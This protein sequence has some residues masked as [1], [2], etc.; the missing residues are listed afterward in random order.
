LYKNFYYYCKQFKNLNLFCEYKTH[1]TRNIQRYTVCSKCPGTIKSQK[2]II[3]EKNVSCKS[4][5][6][7]S[8]AL[9]SNVNDFG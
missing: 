9:H 2:Q 4:Y 6:A 8:S 5:R 3:F 1:I 7:L